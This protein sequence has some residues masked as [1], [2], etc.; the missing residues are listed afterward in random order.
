MAADESG[1]MEQ[2]ERLAAEAQLSA[3][4]AVADSGRAVEQQLAAQGFGPWA[5]CSWARR[6]GYPATWASRR[7]P[8]ARTTSRLAAAGCGGAGGYAMGPSK[9]IVRLSDLLP[10]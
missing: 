2:T 10:G 1:A 6:P 4:Q 9:L 3:I 5:A 8:K 7:R